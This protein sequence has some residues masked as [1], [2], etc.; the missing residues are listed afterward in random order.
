MLPPPPF[1]PTPFKCHFLAI[2]L[3]LAG[4]SSVPGETMTSRG[5]QAEVRDRILT[6]ARRADP[7]CRQ[8]RVSNTE[9]LDVH[10]DGRS[11]AELWTVELCGKRANYLVNFP[12][13]KGA[14]FSIREE[15]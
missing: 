13:K 7:Q 6:L 1:L 9:I 3:L 4:C 15:P 5:V 10:S 2:A 8:P 11:A 12:I 14:G